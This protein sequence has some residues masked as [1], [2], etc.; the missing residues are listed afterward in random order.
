MKPLNHLLGVS[1]FT[2]FSATVAFGQGNIVVASSPA[3]SPL[4][5]DGNTWASTCNCTFTT[6]DDGTVSEIPFN[7]IY[8]SAAE[9]S[10]DLAGGGACGT[11]DIVDNPSTGRD[12]SY[13]YYSDPNGVPNSG[14][15]YVIY[16]LRVAK[17]PGNANFGFSVLIDSDGLMGRLDPNYISG[18]PGFEREIRVVNGGA[19]KGVYVD[20]VDGRTTGLNLKFYTL[21]S[22]TQRVKSLYTDAA[23]NVSNVIFYDFYVMLSDLG[24]AATAPIRLVTATSVNGSTA[25]SAGASDIGGVN[26]NLMNTYG[27]SATANMDSMFTTLVKTQPAVTFGTLP[28]SLLYFKAQTQKNQTQLVWATASEQNNDYF[29]IEKSENGKDFT[30]IGTVHGAGNSQKM[31][32]YQY[33]DHTPLYQKTYYRLKQVDFDGASK[34]SPI[35]VIANGKDL[36]RNLSVTVNNKNVADFEISAQEDFSELHIM[37][38]LG[39]NIKAQHYYNSENEHLQIVLPENHRYN[40]SVYIIS[41]NTTQGIY[42]RKIRLN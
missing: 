33:T 11:T 26:D 8:Q 29:S 19:S 23:C 41:I 5:P 32:N 36:T 31:L 25:L 40:H 28:V 22:H 13:V 2:L 6:N 1:I 4:N 3:A 14:D 39:K 7:R 38:M 30:A 37:D 34:Y 35:A 27:G 20:N 24:L 21:T 16:R 9:P 18:N 15:E 17:D 12:A 42:S 10:G